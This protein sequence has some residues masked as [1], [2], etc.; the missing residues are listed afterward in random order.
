MSPAPK[1][2]Q[3]ALGNKGGR[4]TKY[5]EEICCKLIDM[6]RN[7]MS[8]EE[9]CYDLDIGHDTFYRWIKE[10]PEFSETIK[11]G[12][13]L[14]EAWWSRSGRVNLKE[15]EFNY[16]GWY[17]NMK[18][19][20]GWADKKEIESKNTHIHE[21]TDFSGMTDEEIRAIANRS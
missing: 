7:G 4:P 13:M 9:A 21:I 20:F 14:S 6:F 11:K 3:Y 8:V 10:E 5:N 1:G 17:M 19:R 15:R 18:N 12:Q 2:N 16:T